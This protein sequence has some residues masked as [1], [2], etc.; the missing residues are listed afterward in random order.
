MGI[1]AN[2]GA[3]SLA[4]NIDFFPCFLQHKHIN[5]TFTM[6]TIHIMLIALVVSTPLPTAAPIPSPVRLPA[7]LP[8][9]DTATLPANCPNAL[10]NPQK[11]PDWAGAMDPEHCR[12]TWNKFR[13]CAKSF[14]PLHLFMFWS[15]RWM[16]KPQGPAMELPFGARHG[17]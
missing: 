3:S 13:F 7:S 2:R 9:A 10:V 12:A 17:I 11:H 4:H 14:P 8:N 6:F 15:R 1:T 16:K 5:P